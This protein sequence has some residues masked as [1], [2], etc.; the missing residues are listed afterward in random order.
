MKKK[1]ERL[2]EEGKKKRI[3]LEI[4]KCTF[5]PNLRSI[6]KSKESKGCTEEEAE[7]FYK[8]G[9]DWQTRLIQANRVKKCEKNNEQ[10]KQYTFSPQI[11]R[12]VPF[13]TFLNPGPQAKMGKKTV[14]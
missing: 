9:I 6:S 2:F 8:K 12:Y 1:R 5:S 4:N 13:S 10:I 7:Q 14:V 3:D 11:V